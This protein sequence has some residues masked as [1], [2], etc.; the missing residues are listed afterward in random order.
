MK[1]LSSDIFLNRVKHNIDQRRSNFKIMV[2]IFLLVK[3]ELGNQ[4]N[5]TSKSS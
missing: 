3:G 5:K 4:C 2:I 1:I